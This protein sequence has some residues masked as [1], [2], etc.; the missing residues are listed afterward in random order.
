[1]GARA[2]L[3][4]TSLTPSCALTSASWR[5]RTRP[6]AG[7]LE[8]LVD[9]LGRLSAVLQPLQGLLVVDGDARRLL[10]GVVLADDLDEPAVTRRAAVRRH[11]AVARLLGLADS[12]E[13]ELHCHGSVLFLRCVPGRA[14][15]RAPGSE[16]LS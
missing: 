1:M 13:P 6:G 14:G 2:S 9:A 3:A 4:S 8:A 15:V 7:D 12:H 5:P 11:D 10:T 16:R